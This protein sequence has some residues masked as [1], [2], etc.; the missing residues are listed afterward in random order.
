MRGAHERHE[1]LVAAQQW[2]DVVERGRVVAMRRA[3]GEERGEVED[4]DAEAL[5][6]VEMRLDAG[7]VAA[8]PLAR[9]LRPRSRSAASSHSRGTA[10]SGGTRSA[11][12]RAKR[13]GKTW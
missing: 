10:Q 5:E 4:R 9:R 7:E 6:V 2:V 1:R 11:P 12:E 3:G 8:E 13:S